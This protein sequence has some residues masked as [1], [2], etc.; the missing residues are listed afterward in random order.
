VLV[1]GIKTHNL[2]FHRILINDIEQRESLIGIN[3]D[4]VGDGNGEGDQVQDGSESESEDSGA[5]S[6]T[7]DS[8]TTDP[9]AHV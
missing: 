6:P 4:H 2:L 1:L 3:Y 9:H 5:H 8:P 7:I